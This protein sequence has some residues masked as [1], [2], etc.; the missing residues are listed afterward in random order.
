MLIKEVRF[1]DDNKVHDIYVENGIIRCIDCQGKKDDYVFYGKKRLLIPPFVNPHSH[2]GYA[3]TLNYGS[4]NE[5]GTLREGVIKTREEITPKI[6]FDDIEK[7]LKKLEK[8]FFV[9]GVL[10]VR[11]HEIMPLIFYVLE[12]RKKL[13]L[14][15]LQ[16]VAFPS[17]GIFYFEDT[18]EKMEKALSEGAEVV[19][20][21]PNQEPTVELGIESVKIAF[22]LALKYNKMVDGHIDENDDPNSRFVEYVTYEALKRKW[23]EK[24]TI[25]HMTASHSYPSDYFGKLVDLMKLAKVNVISNPV[26]ST[27][28][29]GRYDNYPKRRGIARIRDMLKSGINVA[30][31][32]DNI[33]D[34][35]YPLGDGNMLRVLQEAFLVDHFTS[36]D[37]E[38]M[39][40]LVT[41][42]PAKILMLDDYGIKPGRK[43]EFVVLNAKNEYE[44]IR[45]IL[46]PALVVSGENIAENEIEFKIN[47]KDVTGEIENLLDSDF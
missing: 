15:N 13:E 24:T 31:G 46:P 9:N 18:I 38:G 30:L 36:K 3:L 26:V 34:L 44:A 28:L 41:Y 4:V 42:N 21:I 45:N 32:T 47:D 40:K 39:L 10:Y 23:G 12:A 29:Q 43:A 1:Y 16:I 19:G 22:D 35:I 33:G 6:T 11:S 5:S 25:S 2:L 37:I 14:I 27:H 17:P 20:L 7:R 8:L